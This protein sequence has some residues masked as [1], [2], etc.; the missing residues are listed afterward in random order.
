MTDA[1]THSPL[2]FSGM[3]P[4]GKLHLGNYLGAIVNWLKM[5]D[6]HPCMFCI[7]DLHAITMP[8]EPAELREATRTVAAAYFAA[9]VDPKRSIVFNQAQV[10]QHTEL[11]WLF[12]CVARLG[13]LDRMTQFKDKAGK[14]SERQS[15]G[16]YDYPVLMA[17]DILLYKATHVPVGD[18][19]KQHVELTRDIAG[20]FNNDFKAP[21]FFPIPE[22]IIQG[23]AT[24]VMSLRD[25]AAKMSKSDVSD[26]SR[27][28]LTDDADA[29]AN[30]IK[31]AKSDSDALPS[32]VAG[33]KGR[34]EAEN[35]LSIY[36]AMSGESLEAAV[37]RFAGQQFSA[38]KGQL[39]DVLT[40]RLAPF[41]AE[42]RRWLADPAMIDAELAKGA[43]AAR[44]RAEPIMKDVRRIFGFAGA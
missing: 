35:L 9:G 1:P 28:N 12:N 37:T 43:E 18:D 33:L 34:P 3:Q 27:I 17:A 25:G 23:P 5:Q 36:A 8:H 40:A 4:T 29:I 44:A 2:V 7:V 30:K 38:L 42:M 24:R 39:A 14:N 13:W 10:P 15:V 22:P 6:Q 31:R 41:N 20:K 21:G 19:Q 11:T 26:A 32:D 16:L